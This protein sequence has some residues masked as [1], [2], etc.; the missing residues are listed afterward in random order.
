MATR[1][2]N[3]RIRIGGDAS[4]AVAAMSRARQGVKDLA[5]QVG[6]LKQ[7]ALGAL[8]FTGLAA[9]V[10]T[11]VRT[12]DEIAG[13]NARLRL[14]TASQGEFNRAQAELAQIAQRNQA[15]L[16]ATVTLYTRLDGAVRALKGGQAEALKITEAVALSLRIT[17]ASAAESSSTILQFSQAM[18]SG[19]LRGEEFNAINEAA[20]RLLQALADGL[21]RPKGELK[22]L[23]EQG[24]LT[25]D[26][27]GNALI[28]QLGRLE[29]EAQGLPQTVGGAVQ[30]LQNRFTQFVGSSKEIQGAMVALAGAINLVADNIGPLLAALTA[31]LAVFV[32]LKAAPLVALLLSWKGAFLAAST[33]TGLLTGALTAL[34]T[35]LLGPVGIILLVGTLL[36]NA[37]N[38]ARIEK[39]RYAKAG[40]EDLEAERD[41]LTKEIA[42]LQAKADSERGMYKGI[43][44]PQQ[45][46]A[47]ERLNT[48]NAELDRRNAQSFSEF[49]AGER[50]SASASPEGPLRSNLGLES[51]RKDYQSAIQIRK[52]YIEAV[53]NI[54]Q[55]ADNDRA[56]TNDPR[57]EA[58]IE[59]VRASYLKQAAKK[60][61][62]DLKALTKDE[63]QTRLA[64]YKA[65]FDQFLALTADLIERE[66]AANEDRYAQG[67]IS[68]REY[69][70]ERKRLENEASDASIQRVQ[71]E[72]DQQREILAK[73][74]VIAKRASTANERSQAEESIKS[75]SER[76]KELEVE[77]IKLQRE[78]LAN[79]RERTTAEERTARAIAQQKADQADELRNLRG[80]TTE[81]DAR[82][83]SRRNTE[84][85]NRA[86]PN[87]PISPEL[88]GARETAAAIEFQ[89]QAYR[90]LYDQLRTDEEAVQLLRSQGAITQEQAEQRLLQLRGTAAAQLGPIVDRLIELARELG[91]PDLVRQAQELQQQL[92]GVKDKTTEL[93]RTARSAGENGLANFFN[94]VST[95]AKSAKESVADFA[96]SFL[97]T[98][99]D[100]INRRLAAQLFQSIG[101]SFQGGFQ[102]HG[103]GVVG[104]G[105]TPRKVNPLWF[106]GAPKY[107]SGGI[108]GL[109]PNEV[110]AILERGERVL[111][112]EQQR[113]MGSASGV[114]VMMDIKIEGATGNEQMQRSAAEDLVPMIEA[115]VQRWTA[116]QSRDGGM[117]SGA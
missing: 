6:E 36:A 41:R 106:A 88:A 4:G 72:L 50:A 68:L 58:E 25:A 55:A 83:T 84:A 30:N 82:A 5:S 32:A 37:W 92:G 38:N 75:T 81:A 107:H 103:G 56:R 86:N 105:G 104:Q 34:R 117:L 40:R 27:V 95:G 97:R 102:F 21:G 7:L 46:R 52:D 17:G 9:G 26:V 109:A 100:L 74:E 3:A 67:L 11:V 80:T 29:R 60:R 43:R 33:A 44:T 19:V 64:V 35:V 13:L 28:G 99:L 77:I 98:M 76:I 61:D 45:L 71:Q 12:A 54:N 57:K 49:R 31:V 59:A 113:R 48:V 85:F 93:E 10:Q 110:P 91:N 66:R 101:S 51:L 87:A 115:V 78:R 96:R 20:P 62:D 112:K 73:N 23:A 16:N 24:K 39:E 1:D 65:E 42:D 108:A 2:I 116:R 14:A 53:K 63:T 79:A 94:D 111:T 89:Q 22:A 90:R 47:Q 114:N 8:G 70:D 18:A 69:F 15:P